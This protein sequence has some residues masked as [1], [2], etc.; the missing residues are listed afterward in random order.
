MAQA[1]RGWKGGSHQHEDASGAGV[2]AR[3]D[4]QAFAPLGTTRV[5]DGATA[6]GLHANAKAVGAL[7]TGDGRLESAFH[8]GSEKRKE[9]EFLKSPPFHQISVGSSNTC[10]ILNKT[11]QFCLWITT[12]ST[13]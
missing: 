6:T 9:Q 1:G 5:N 10:G 8:D 2:S 4:G 7:A 11:W 12:L 3:L 13:G